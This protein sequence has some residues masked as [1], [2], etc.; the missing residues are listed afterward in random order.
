MATPSSD[1]E[2]SAF[3]GGSNYTPSTPMSPEA[4]AAAAAAAA[5]RR[6]PHGGPSPY[7]LQQ[8]QQ[9]QQQQQRRGLTLADIRRRNLDEQQALRDVGHLKRYRGYK[10]S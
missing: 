7:T 4:A 2:G 9:Q 8:Q 10:M 1:R 5:G 6:G 3:G